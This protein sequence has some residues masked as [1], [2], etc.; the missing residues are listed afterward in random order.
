MRGSRGGLGG[1]PVGGSG[2]RYDGQPEPR[3]WTG[4]PS[5]CPVETLE[6]VRPLV[7]R[8]SRAVVAYLDADPALVGGGGDRT[9]RVVGRV[10]EYVRAEVVDSSPQQF[11]ITRYPQ[12]VGDVDLPAAAGIGNACPFGTVGHERG[13]VDEFAGLA[14]M[15]AEPGE[16]EHVVDQA[17][18]TLGLKG[19]PAHHLGDLGGL[20]EDTVLMQFG[21]GEQRRERRPQFVAG[22]GEE[23]A[24][25][26]LAGLAFL[27][28]GFDPGEHAVQGRS[29]SAHFAAGAVR[30]HP[31]REIARGDPVGLRGH[32]LDR[33]QAEAEHQEDPGA[34][35]QHHD[36]RPDDDDAL[37]LG[38]GVRDWVQ[39]ST[40]DYQSARI[41]GAVQEHHVADDGYRVES[42]SGNGLADGVLDGPG[43][44]CIWYQK[45]R[46]DLN[47]ERF[48]VCRQ[49]DEVVLTLDRRDPRLDRG[50]QLSPAGCRCAQLAPCLPVEV[51]AHR[52]DRDEVEGSEG[53]EYNCD[54]A[55]HHPH[56]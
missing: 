26:L 30:D 22:V 33:P 45:A 49:P 2:R 1:A 7:R 48:T 39:G 37:D 23:L 55:G 52:A 18:H 16:V 41:A 5:A 8:H 46:R 56:P 14:G 36:H 28:R 40:H 29:Q 42:R 54:D 9:R 25:L 21:V 27:H 51:I 50:L 24:R 35:E 20:G 13:Q 10:H 12:P 32:R 19:H 3:S 44:D 53:R 34:D 11:L 38:Y 4:R 43:V 31:V 6:D 47:C 17:S 15:L